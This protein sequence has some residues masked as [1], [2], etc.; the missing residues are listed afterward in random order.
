MLLESLQR[1]LDK[2]TDA[3]ELHGIFSSFLAVFNAVYFTS[4]T[5]G[6]MVEGKR[7]L[8]PM[9]PYGCFDHPWPLHYTR[10]NFLYKDAALLKAVAHSNWE[11]PVL[12]SEVDW[13]DDSKV[14]LAEAAHMG[15]DEGAVFP[16]TNA[17]GSITIFSVAGARFKPSQQDLAVMAAGAKRM[18]I[19]VMEVEGNLALLGAGDLPTDHVRVLQLMAQGMSNASIAEVISNEDG[20]PITPDGIKK[21]V[22]KIYE[23]TGAVNRDDAVFLGLR[24]SLI[25]LR[26]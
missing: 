6:R 2:T 26:G 4:F 18:H 23:T 15:L 13:P 8:K 14:I 3:L 12:W 5:F 1:D 17:D 9:N 25:T 7:H 24:H 21:R 19:R 20:N 11:L 22:A 10:R 16:I